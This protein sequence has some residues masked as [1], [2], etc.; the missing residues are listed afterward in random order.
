M[1]YN[2]GYVDG[3]IVANDAA[4]TPGV[5]LQLVY[6]NLG[7]GIS[8]W[9][10]VTSDSLAAVQASGYITDA[11]F[12]RLKVGDIV[13]VF[14]GTLVSETPSAAAGAKLGAVTFPAV[15][16]LIG[17]FASVPTYQRMIVSNVTVST[18][19]NTSGVGT[20]QAVEPNSLGLSANPRNM[21]DGGDF[22]TNPWQSGTTFNGTGTTVKVTADRFLANAGTSLVWNA[23]QQADTSV[24][25]FST[26]LQWGRSAGDTH[27]TGLTIGQVLETADAIRCQG[28]PVTLSWYG[29]AGANFAAGA[30]GGILTTVIYSGTGTNDTFANMVTGGWTGTTVVA[31]AAY[32]PGLSPAVRVNPLSGT[33]PT[34]CT[35]LGVAWSYQPT[36]AASSPGITA[37]ANE[38]VR[39][40]GTQLELGAMTPFEHLDVAE[41]VN[42]CTRYLQVI[43]EPTTGMAIGPAAFSASTIA[44]VHI[45][46]PSPMRKAPTVTFNT[47]GWAITDSALAAHLVS[48][49]GL[50]VGN[51]G[52][53]TLLAT[54]AATLTAGLVSFLQGRSTGLGSITLYA[55]Y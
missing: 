13:D 2:P 32:T 21:L 11:T 7:S 28:L 51:T 49:A 40:I 34:N 27:T 22:G 25:G 52:A 8:Y 35:Q 18:S 4:Y 37:G 44:Q 24:Q 29:A 3:N 17:M 14:T 36:T 6:D 10:Y 47:G 53:V 15:L 55:D 50:Q 43:S 31:S 41:V 16:G 48:A 54:C 19:P 9:I 46:L 1:P 33:V 20:L 26:A 45:P 39:F 38:Y 12:K 5:G 42:I 23:S 30:S